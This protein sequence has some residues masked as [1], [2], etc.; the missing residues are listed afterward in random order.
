MGK[1]FPNYILEQGFAA[2]P[3]LQ[4]ILTCCNHNEIYPNGLV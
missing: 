2:V 4:P 1:S 3:T